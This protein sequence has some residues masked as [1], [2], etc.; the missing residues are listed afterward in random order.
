[1][2]IKIIPIS[3]SS[4]DYGDAIAILRND[5]VVDA[6]PAYADFVNAHETCFESF[7]IKNDI[8]ELR[9]GGADAVKIS[10][11]LTRGGMT[12]QLMFGLN[13]DLTEIWINGNLMNCGGGYE[14]T[15]SI[16][17]QNGIIVRSACKGEFLNYEI[18]KMFEFLFW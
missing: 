11:I 17:I 1:M 16:K 15:P 2:C 10:V 12:T 7:D 18:Q 5:E 4:S 9:N 13:E 8:F 14:T 3:G 6:T